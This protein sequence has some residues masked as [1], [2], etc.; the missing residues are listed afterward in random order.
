MDAFDVFVE[1]IS[2]HN[3][4]VN[5]EQMEQAKGFQVKNPGIALID[6]L[7]RARL[8]KKEHVDAIHESYRRQAAVGTGSQTPEASAAPVTSAAAG[9]GPTTISG[10]IQRY[11]EILKNANGSDLHL[12]VNCPPLM[13]KD[14]RFVPLD[15]G[16]LAA[17]DCEALLMSVLDEERR[18]RLLKQQYL[19]TSLSLGPDR[20]RVCILKQKNGWDGSF[21]LI[22]N[23]VMGP[24]ELG[25]NEKVLME[26]MGYHQGLVLVTG[27]SGCGK[28][29]TV[30]AMLE[31]VNRAR[32]CH[33]ITLE[34]PIEYVFTSAK[35]HF[36]QRQLIE[37]TASFSAALR[38]ALREDPD[39]IMIGELRDFETASLAITAAETGHLVISTLHTTSAIRTISRLIDMFPA[40]QRQ[41]VRM[42]LSEAMRGIVCQK[43][44]PVQ[45]GPGR[46]L[47]AE[48]MINTPAVGSLVRKEQYLQLPSVL[49]T[50]LAKGMRTMDMSVQE[51]FKAGTI[52]G[53]E[54]YFAAEN[55][56][57]YLQF[58]PK[59]D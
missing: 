50:S 2:L 29:T 7:F 6:V 54:A 4:L 57:P 36:S 13:R 27:P 52:S 53:E 51:L 14:G 37:H 42:M 56:A 55:Q 35:S 10:R 18:Q 59:E 1:K 31:I 16:L 3:K 39:V 43:L 34:D 11:F 20:Y 5:S 8:L 44:I 45:S 58:A 15:Q 26:L 28:S 21:R 47:A 30:A 49:Q 48:I 17:K 24:N 46:V 9:A 41:Q 12:V 25:L 32:E 33:I 23:K 38:A 40:D 22:K 19:D